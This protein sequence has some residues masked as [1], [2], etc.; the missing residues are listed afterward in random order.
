MKATIHEMHMKMLGLKH[1]KQV[2]DE[3]N[4]ST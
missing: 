1:L 2:S 4:K 3:E